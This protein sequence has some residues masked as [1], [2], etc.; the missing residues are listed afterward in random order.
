M[1]RRLVPLNFL[2]PKTGRLGQGS[3]S[4]IIRVLRDR[5]LAIRVSCCLLRIGDVVVR[6]Y[7]EGSTIRGRG[8]PFTLIPPLTFDLSRNN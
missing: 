3:R 1:D 6:N 2:S 5:R 7:I 4:R 8:P